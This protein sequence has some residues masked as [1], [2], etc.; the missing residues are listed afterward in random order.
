MRGSNGIPDYEK[1]LATASDDGCCKL[2]TSTD[3]A[4]LYDLRGHDSRCSQLKKNYS[5]EM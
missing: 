1:V 5:A 3:G 4:S 2:W